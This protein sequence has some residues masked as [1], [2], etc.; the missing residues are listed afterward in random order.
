MQLSE[1]YQLSMT[2][3]MSS[4]QKKNWQCKFLQESINL[5]MQLTIKTTLCTGHPMSIFRS[6]PPAEVSEKGG[7]Y[8]CHSS[9]LPLPQSSHSLSTPFKTTLLY[10]LW[11]VWQVRFPCAEKQAGKDNKILLDGDCIQSWNDQLDKKC[12]L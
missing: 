8:S 11:D 12:S 2:V 5:L 10:M 4:S 3:N 9:S 7:F 6:P 1:F